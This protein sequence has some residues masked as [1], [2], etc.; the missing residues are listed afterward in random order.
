MTEKRSP[1]QHIHP[2]ASDEDFDALVRQVMAPSSSS[3]SSSVHPVMR[4]VYR[5]I[6]RRLILAALLLAVIVGSAATLL[7]PDEPAPLY[8]ST[9]ARVDTPVWPPWPPSWPAPSQPCVRPFRAQVGQL[10]RVQLA[11]TP[12]L[13]VRVDGCAADPAWEHLL[14]LGD[15]D[16]EAY[17]V[18][19]GHLHR[20]RLTVTQAPAAIE[21]AA[22]PRHADDVPRVVGPAQ[23]VRID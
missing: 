17:D 5:I 4:G 20:Y 21:V 9:F 14:G 19:A 8:G 6:A 22:S 3:S 23:F 16:V 12:M 2:E 7:R 10:A 18:A 15:H 13:E 11:L 1:P